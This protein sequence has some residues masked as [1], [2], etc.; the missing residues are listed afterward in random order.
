MILQARAK[1][2]KANE[3]PHGILWTAEQCLD[4]RVSRASL[5][6]ALKIMAS[7][8]ALIEREGFSVSMGNGHREQTT[9]T[10]YGQTIKF[11]LVERVERVEASVA[12]AGG[13]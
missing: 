13:L 1:L 5:D 12:P 4:I 7:L 8:V 11:G 2:A 10:I 3:N 6:R 9:A